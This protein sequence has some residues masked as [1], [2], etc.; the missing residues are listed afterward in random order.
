[1]EEK[2]ATPHFIEKKVFSQPPM[3]EKKATPHRSVGILLF[4]ARGRGMRDQWRSHANSLCQVA[5]FSSDFRSLANKKM[6][7]HLPNIERPNADATMRSGFFFFHRGPWFHGSN[8]CTKER[9]ASCLMLNSQ[10]PTLRSSDA[11]ITDCN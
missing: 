7:T 8:F 1:M 10:S 3:E 5:F 9:S 2:Q 4:N 6:V 11:M